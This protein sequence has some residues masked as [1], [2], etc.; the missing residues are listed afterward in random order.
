MGSSMKSWAH[1]ITGPT[2]AVCLAAG[3]VAAGTATADPATDGAALVAL[4]DSYSANAY[5]WVQ[6]EIFGTAHCVQSDTSW[7]V[8]LRD[9]M[10]LT[11]ADTANHA[12]AGASVDTGPGYTAA[13]EARDAAQDGAF[14]PGT[15]LVTLQFGMNDTWGGTRQT[16]WKAIGQCV[17][18]VVDGCAEDAVDQGRIP[19]HRA[20]TGPAYADRIRNVV[21][22]IRYYAPNARI[23]F[24]GYPEIAAPGS[25]TVCLNLFGV[26]PIV[27][28]R[29]G[30]ALEYFDAVD[31]AQREAAGL[32][33]VEFLDA[34]A[35]TA[36]HGLCSDRPW[37][38]GVV[39][40]RA[41]ASGL[42]F[43]PS[44]QG[45]AVLANALYDIAVQ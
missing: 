40:P 24:V 9:R 22:Y 17:L 33:G 2:V 1:R 31:R 23:V 39:D 42:P 32:L 35:L 19:D 25:N 37:L 13:L 27:Q 7:P 20:V 10:G 28:S 26:A 21:D 8:Q 16:M 4:G 12:C 3:V 38:N 29:A 15:R 6:G 14:G 43:H 44:V 45:D 34:R 41:D 30:A 18:N 5:D 36:G 11:A